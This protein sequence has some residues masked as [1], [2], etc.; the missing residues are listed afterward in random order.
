MDI[1]NTTHSSFS[2]P[3]RSEELILQV[4]GT[5]V[6][7]HLHSWCTT[8]SVDHF[9]LYKHLGPLRRI[10]WRRSVWHQVRLE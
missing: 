4:S 7:I 10:C 1:R 9:V 5:P 3:L 8:P 6:Q 2:C